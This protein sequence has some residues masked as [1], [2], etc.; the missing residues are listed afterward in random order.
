MPKSTVSMN[1]QYVDNTIYSNMCCTT[2][3]AFVT[4]IYTTH[5]HIYTTPFRKIILFI[6]YPM[7]QKTA[8]FFYYIELGHHMLVFYPF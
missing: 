5:A 2:F 6:L 1:C 7:C 3:K 4:S 8:S